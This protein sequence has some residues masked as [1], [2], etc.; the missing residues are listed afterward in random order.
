MRHRISR[1]FGLVE[2][3][4]AIVLGLFF[5]DWPLHHADQ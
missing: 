1:G 3:M 2:I 5:I 4:I